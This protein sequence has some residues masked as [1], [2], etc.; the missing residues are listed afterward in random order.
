MET[1]GAAAAEPGPLTLSARTHA[2]HMTCALRRT[3]L[4]G[5][6]AFSSSCPVEH[7]ALGPRRADEARFRSGIVYEER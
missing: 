3:W 5:M 2:Q 7:P 1:L 4:R 6:A